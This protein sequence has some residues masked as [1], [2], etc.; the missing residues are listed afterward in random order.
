MLNV[1]F[2]L[3]STLNDALTGSGAWQYC[4]YD[5]PSVG[6]PRDCGPTGS[7]WWQ[8]NSWSKGWGDQPDVAFEI[9]TG[10]IMKQTYEPSSTPSSPS[11]PIPHT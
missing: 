1:D 11:S 2:Q 10:I 4:D 7:V 8:W 3:F 5:D 6:F 9:Y